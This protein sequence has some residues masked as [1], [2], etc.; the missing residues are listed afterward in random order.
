[1]QRL[2][3]FSTKS[4]LELRVLLP[5][6]REAGIQ[7]REFVSDQSSCKHE[8]SENLE[9]SLTGLTAKPVKHTMGLTCRSE[10]AA[11][12]PAIVCGFLA[13]CRAFVVHFHAWLKRHL[14]R[15][16][17]RT[18]PVAVAPGFTLTDRLLFAARSGWTNPCAN[19]ADRPISGI[20]RAG[21]CGRREGAAGYAG[22][23]E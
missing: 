8:Y 14:A 5:R 3:G 11:C 16:F 4:V 2:G 20:R 23:P 13:E 19:S 17:L 9:Q 18:A 21:A 15:N 6:L 10:S 22:Q 7:R 1:M 12:V